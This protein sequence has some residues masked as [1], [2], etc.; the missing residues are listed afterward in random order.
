M[1]G[2][3]RVGKLR[4]G[5]RVKY[6]GRKATVLGFPTRNVVSLRV[7]GEKE[8]TKMDINVFWMWQRNVV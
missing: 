4:K 2:L 5:M 6:D 7:D 1:S 3:R 8:P